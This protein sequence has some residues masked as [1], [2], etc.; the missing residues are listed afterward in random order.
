M[1][2]KTGCSSALDV[3][4]WCSASTS[5]SNLWQWRGSQW[6]ACSLQARSFGGSGTASSRWLKVARTLADL[7]G[8]DA[9]RRLH[10]AEALAYR[11]VIPGRQSHR[12]VAAAG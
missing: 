9:V 3:S 7:D 4:A 5:G 10:I 2:T 1:S 8:S 11:R 6:P 12:A